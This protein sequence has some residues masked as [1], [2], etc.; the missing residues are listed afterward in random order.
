MERKRKSKKQKENRRLKTGTLDAEEGI[1]M[2]NPQKKRVK[3]GRLT[4]RKE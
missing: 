4:E 3:G 2:E 1:E